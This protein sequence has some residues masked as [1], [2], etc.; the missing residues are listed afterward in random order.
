MIIKSLLDTDLYKFTMMQAV[1]HQFTDAQVEYEFRCRDENVDL[2]S[3]RELIAEDVFGLRHRQFSEDELKYL[4]SLRFIKPDFIEFLRLFRFDPKAV[5]IS[6]IHAPVAAPNKRLRITVKGSWLHTIL[7]EVPILA[8]VN[9]LYFRRELAPSDQRPL[10]EAYPELEKAGLA[11]LDKKVAQVRDY[12]SSQDKGAAPFLITEFGTRRR[13]AQ[14]WQDRAV[15]LLAEELPNNFVGTSNVHL[16]MKY[17]LTPFGT[18]AHEYQ[19]AMQAMVRLSESLKYSLQTWADEYRGDL[20]IALSD[21]VGFDAFLRDFDL[22]FCKLFDGC[23]HD[24]GDPF[25]WAEKLIAHY[26]SMRI[27]PRTKRAV[28][29]DGLTIPKAIELH[30]RFSDRIEMGFGIGTNLTNDCGPKALNIV[31]KMTRCNGQP[32]A[33]ISDARGKTICEDKEYLA[34]LMKVFQI[35]A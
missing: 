32:V 7:Y 30:K 17:N 8:I 20:G 35:P 24:S 14:I 34:Y 21:V 19:Q 18:Q 22:Y 3:L 25:E 1:F 10:F 26:K 6:E 31:M 33:K 16:A 15:K 11:R 9:E 5:D 28:F 27:D 4:G 29:S 2:S 13:I 12:C 23:R